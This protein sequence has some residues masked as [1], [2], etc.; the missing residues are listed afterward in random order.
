M[1]P[2]ELIERAF[3]DGVQVS[4]NGA[5][6]IKLTGNKTAIK[7]WLPEIK[8]HKEELIRLLFGEPVRKWTV[9]NPFICACGFP[10]GW[11]LNGKVLCPSCFHHQQNGP[12]PDPAGDR[13]A[14][15]DFPRQVNCQGFEHN[16]VLIATTPESCRPWQ[17][18]YCRGCTLYKI[19]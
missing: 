6:K 7:E 4:L 2:T 11:M 8:E 15:G 17:D 3:S 14:P 16:G 13:Q 9:G 12:G 10:T 5:D 18:H 19:Q 1:K